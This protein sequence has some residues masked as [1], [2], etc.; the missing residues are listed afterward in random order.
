MAK[1]PSARPETTTVLAISSTAVVSTAISVG[2]TQVRLA[3]PVAS[4]YAFGTAPV[5]S[6]ATGAYLPPDV[7]EYIT[8][9][10]G[11][12]ISATGSVTGNFTITEVS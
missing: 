6:S 4:W 8:V 2:I 7:V 5:V 12:R 10:P 9:S 3:S 11:Q 1:Q